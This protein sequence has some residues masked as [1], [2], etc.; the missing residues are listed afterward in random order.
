MVFNCALKLRQDQPAYRAT[1]QKPTA[2]STESTPYL[3]YMWTLGITTLSGKFWQR[4]PVTRLVKWYSWE[5]VTVP[6]DRTLREFKSEKEII[7]TNAAN[8]KRSTIFWRTLPSVC[9]NVVRWKNP[10][11]NLILVLFWKAKK[12]SKQWSSFSF[13]FCTYSTDGYLN[14]IACRGFNYLPSHWEIRS[15][16]KGFPLTQRLSPWRIWCHWMSIPQIPVRTTTWSA[17]RRKVL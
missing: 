5:P 4:Q 7:T 3:E 8:L 11:R 6:W 2:A 13:H 1:T 9:L 10:S 17:S 15:D 14:S 12:A 16:L